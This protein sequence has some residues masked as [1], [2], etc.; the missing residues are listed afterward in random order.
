MVYDRKKTHTNGQT[1]Q[2][3]NLWILSNNLHVPDKIVYVQPELENNDLLQL[4]TMIPH[5]TYGTEIKRHLHLIMIVVSSMFIT[6]LTVS[7][8]LNFSTHN[9]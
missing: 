4:H 7:F 2:Y 3:G 1:K 8:L 9:H 6:T 5:V